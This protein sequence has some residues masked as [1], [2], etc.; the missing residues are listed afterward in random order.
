[1]IM[2]VLL[3]YPVSIHMSQLLST[4]RPIS[5]YIYIYIYCIFQATKIQI[6]KDCEKIKPWISCEPIDT[7]ISCMVRLCWMMTIQRPP[8]TFDFTEKGFDEKYQELFWGSVNDADANVCVV[9]PLLK[10]GG[11][12][13]GK[14]KIYLYKES[15]TTIRL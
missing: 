11:R 6:G 3:C 1:M 5:S 9:F 2:C 8:M 4:G 7:Y 13:M 15:K 12:V 14:G 10:H